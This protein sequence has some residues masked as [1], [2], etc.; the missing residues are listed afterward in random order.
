[1]GTMFDFS[2]NPKWFLEKLNADFPKLETQVEQDI[3]QKQG[4]NITIPEFYGK[5]NDLRIRNPWVSEEDIFNRWLELA[6]QKWYTVNGKSIR[7]ALWLA[8]VTEPA[9]EPVTEPTRVPTPE[10]PTIFKEHL[11]DLIA[12]IPE[13]ITFILETNGILLDEEFVKE[14]SKFENLYVRVSL[15]GVDEETFEKITGAE[16]KF[17]ENQLLALELLKKYEIRHRAA[18]LYDLFTDAQIQRLGI[19]NIEYET[20]IRYPFVLNNL[21]KRGILIKRELW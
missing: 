11:L 21:N 14:L 15:K 5:L 17:F 12:L 18:I 7:E 13:S 6:D 16:G 19:P 1:M 8:P 4:L 3:Q 20:L 9:I 10:E 2:K